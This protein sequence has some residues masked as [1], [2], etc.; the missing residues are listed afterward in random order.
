ME[1]IAFKNHIL[2]FKYQNKIVIAVYQH[3]VEDT[4]SP[5]F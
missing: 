5:K 3:F 1:T 4:A 2:I